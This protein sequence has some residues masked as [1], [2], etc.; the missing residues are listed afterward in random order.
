MQGSST[1][2][3]TS[4]AASVQVVDSEDIIDGIG[5]ADLKSIKTAHNL[6]RVF[7]L[8]DKL[9]QHLSFSQDEFS[10]KIPQLLMEVF[11][12]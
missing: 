11:Y 7:S 12:T 8:E 6:A 5:V 9:Q 3:T 4:S 10:M 1:L 2:L